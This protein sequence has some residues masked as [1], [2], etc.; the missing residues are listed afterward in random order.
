[1][2]LD[3]TPA[4][5][6][7]L[8]YMIHKWDD[9]TPLQRSLGVAMMRGHETPEEAAAYLSVGIDEIHEARKGLSGVLYDPGGNKLWFQ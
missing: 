7:Q 4:E 8:R 6:R 1:M 3:P 9:R 5:E 2:E